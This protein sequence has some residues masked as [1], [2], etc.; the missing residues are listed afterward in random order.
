MSESEESSESVKLELDIDK[1]S[2]RTSDK[3]VDDHPKKQWF[4]TPAGL[5]LLGGVLVAIIGGSFSWLDNS[6]DLELEKEKY[7]NLKKIERIKLKKSLLDSVS[8]TVEKTNPFL[9]QQ[10]I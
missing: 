5:T 8:N 10:N 1:I 7:K 3:N 4:N 9:F 2:I 6:N